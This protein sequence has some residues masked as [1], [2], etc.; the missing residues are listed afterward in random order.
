MAVNY[1]AGGINWTPRI[2]SIR[3]M[4]IKIHL[5]LPL[6]ATVLLV[7]SL[8]LDGVVGFAYAAIVIVCIFVLILWHEL[9]H[10]FAARRSGLRI[11]GIMLWPLGGECQISGGISSPKTEIVVAISGPIAHLLL[12]LAATPVL[13]LPPSL[14][15]IRIAMIASWITAVAILI[16]NLVPMFPLDGGRVLRGL[17]TYKFGD[18]K[19]TL[20]AVRVGQV[21]AALVIVAAL[22]LG[23]FILVALGVFIIM[24]AENE[25]RAARHL[26]YVYNPGARN[27]YAAELGIKEDWSREAVDGYG[28]GEKKPGFFARWRTRR[29]LKKLAGETERR[30]KMKAEVDRILEKVSKEGMPSLTARE[31]KMLKQAS[32]EYRKT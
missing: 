25:W 12:V 9:G 20:I 27:I 21:M 16:F 23:Q 1:S 29:Q 19:A 2:G 6:L 30:E 22:V 7:Q 31:R 28:R 11:N 26:G 13:F 15:I 3:G 17:L 4:E 10:A 24:S 32:D 18:V 14:G 5:L 8:V